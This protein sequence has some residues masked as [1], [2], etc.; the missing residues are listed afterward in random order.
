M[1]PSLDT[2]S[3]HPVLNS[4]TCRG[5][6][7]LGH[8]RVNV[9]CLR[10]KSQSCDSKSDQ[11]HGRAWAWLC[12]FRCLWSVSFLLPVPDGARKHCRSQ[13]AAP[14]SLPLV[15]C[16]H[17]LCSSRFWGLRESSL[18]FRL[19]GSNCLA[20]NGGCLSTYLGKAFLGVSYRLS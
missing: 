13:E 4:E 2:V 3:R 15:G 18:T 10:Q 6:A 19:I 11:K 9:R 5:P 7:T 17:S 16:P 12:C 20:Q 8:L 1:C 14:T